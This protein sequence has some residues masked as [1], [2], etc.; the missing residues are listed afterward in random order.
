MSAAQNLLANPIADTARLNDRLK[1]LSR[2]ANS[3]LYT[4]DGPYEVD[5]ALSTPI[6]PGLDP[7]RQLA[8]LDPATSEYQFLLTK[9]RRQKNRIL[10]ALLTAIE[11]AEGAT[12]SS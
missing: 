3:A 1:R 8:E 11:L 12:A 4:I 10:D 6:L 5:P 7:M 2:V 9:L